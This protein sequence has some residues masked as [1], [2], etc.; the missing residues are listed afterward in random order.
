MEAFQR[1]KDDVTLHLISWENRWP[2][3]VSG[4]STRK[5][6]VSQAPY[7][8]LNCGLHVGD[9][10]EAVIE[11]RKKIAQFAG[12]PFHT[13]TCAEQ[14]HGNQ[15]KIVTKEEMGS[16][17]TSHEDTFKGIDGLLTDKKGVFLASFYADCVPVFF[18]APK[19]NVIGI[20][21]AGWKGTT[22]RIVEQMLHTLEK[23]WGVLPQDVFAA[24]GPSIHECCYEV[25]QVVMDKVYEVLG[26]DGEK[27]ILKTSDDK[28]MLNLQETNR[29]LLEKAGV[30]PYNI[31]LSHLCTGCRTDL[32]FSH[33]KE[34]GKTGRMIA[35]IGLKEV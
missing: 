7:A 23:N 18:Y 19:K 6:G 26:K 24:I 35:F 27:V 30:L 13:W 8:G 5:E 17:R 10:V 33:R 21:H 3:L 9:N 22:S 11:N 28:G 1:R 32:F 25:N 20:A 2:Q 4:F 31:E 29:I 34:G 12:F 16:G 15:V 14:V